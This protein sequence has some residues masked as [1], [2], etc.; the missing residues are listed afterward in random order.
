MI[1]LACYQRMHII[2]TSG[3]RDNRTLLLGDCNTILFRLLEKLLEMLVNFATR[4][5]VFL[6]TFLLLTCVF[7][8]EGN[9]SQLTSSRCSHNQPRQHRASFP[10]ILRSSPPSEQL[11]MV[12]RRPP[13]RLPGLRRT[14]L[15]ECHKPPRGRHC[16]KIMQHA[17]LHSR[18]AL[19]FK[20]IA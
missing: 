17:L 9:A 8:E 10:T 3:D 18:H 4:F 1:V 2:T 14:R 19:P 20:T 6:P 5:P 15:R 13:Y 7:I 11:P 16:L 12:A